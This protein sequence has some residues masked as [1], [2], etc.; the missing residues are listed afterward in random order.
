MTRCFYVAVA[1]LAN[2][3]MAITAPAFDTSRIED[4]EVRACADR[5]LPTKTASQVQK[6]E[7]TGKN[8]HVRT[9]LREIYWRRS[10][11]ND[12]RVLVRMLE[13]IADK[14]VSVLINDDAARNVVSYMTYSP[15]FKRVRRVTGEA[16]FGSILGTDFTYEDFSF[17]YRVDER[18]EVARVE[19]AVLDDFPG[20]VLETIK[21]DDNSHYSMVRFFI[22][23][24]V[25][26]P[27]RTEF[28]APN[29]DLRKELVA[30]REQIR[31]VGEHWVPYLTMMTDLK[32]KTKSTFTV[33]EIVFDPDLDKS[34]FEVQALRLGN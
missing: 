10:Q 5:T 34:I 31:K 13:P 26:L 11:S 18:E 8:G 3:S 19:D 7:I 28:L 25:C 2:L 27:V 1:G 29:G 20:Y 6:V 30:D 22:D 32:L 14:G 17:F 4:A 12:S 15:K 23:K 9:S 33:E 24:D 21:P 16:F